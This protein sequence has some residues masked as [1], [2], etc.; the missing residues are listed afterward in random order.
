MK[1]V[2]LGA[3]YAGLRA[4]L[5]LD[6][7]LRERGRAAAITLVD[8]HPYHQ[9]VQVL[10]VTATAGHRSREAIYALAELLRDTAVRFVQ[11][12]A[13][14]IAP[15]ARQVRL[16]DGGALPY[17]R[18]LIALGAETAYGGVSGAREHT[19]PLRSY[20]QALRIREQLRVRFAQAAAAGDP[21]ERRRLL[22]TAI[23]GGGYTGCQLAG[24]LAAW[25]SD[26]CAETGAPREEV[27]IALLDGGPLLLN[28]FG[29]WATREAERALAELGVSVY[30]NTTVEAV[31]PGALRVSG[32]RL[33]RAGTILWAGGIQAPAILRASGL[34]VDGSGRVLVDRYLR[35]IDQALIF[36][37]GDCAAIPDGAASLVPATASYAMRQ[38]AHLAETLLAELL[39]EAPRPYEPLRL[40]EIVSLGPHFAIGNPLGVP[41]V[42]YPAMLLKKGVE[43]YYRATIE[44]PPR[45]TQV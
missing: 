33:L 35:V 2:I 14:A 5:D 11:G 34:P 36:A 25:A 37:A 13:A 38:G 7:L 21:K 4:A 39:G 24:E 32:G 26:L 15:L 23:V 6:L 45:G 44:G 30:L 29:P 3:G 19:L 20:E 8:Q 28:Q 43:R 12:R 17:D 40:G 31:E 9:I 27:R 41:V 18:L 10:H 16:E 22:T 1:I 42:G